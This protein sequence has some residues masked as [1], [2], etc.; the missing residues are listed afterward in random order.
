MAWPSAIQPSGVSGGWRENISKRNS[1]RNQWPMAAAA[2][3]GG[4]SM[5]YHQYQ[6]MAMAWRIW[7]YGSSK[8]KA[9]SAAWHLWRNQCRVAIAAS[10]AYRNGVSAAA[11]SM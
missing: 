10:M 1:W 6:L 3:G 9:Y 11:V 4:V 8:A 5:A 7:R 2:N